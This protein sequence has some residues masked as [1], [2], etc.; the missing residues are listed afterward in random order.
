M[1]DSELNLKINT[2]ADKSQV[3]DLS[4]AIEKVTQNSQEASEIATSAMENIANSTDSVS[5]EMDNASASTDELADSVENIDSSN[6]D[7][8]TDSINSET[9]ATDEAS[10]STDNLSET[11]G[12]IDSTAIEDLIAQMDGYK[13]STDDANDAT[14][15]LVDAMTSGAV[16]AGINASLMS[17][18][19]AAGNYK[20]TMVRLGYAMSGTSMS[21]EQAQEK[22]GSMISTMTDVTGRGAG[23]ARA[24]LIN[25]G[26][27]GISSEKTLTDSFNAISKSAYQMGQPFD[28]LEGAFQKMVLSGTANTRMLARFGISANDLATAMGVSADEVSDSFK[29]MDE[30]SRASVLAMALNTK[31]GTDVNENYKNSYEHLNEELQRAKDYFIRTAGETLLPTLIPAIQTAADVTNYLTG[32]FRG[33]PE[34]IQNFIGGALGLVGG[35]TAVGLGV[36]AVTKFVSSALSPFGSLWRYF[37]EIPDGQNLTKF[38]SHVESLKNSVRTAK[39]YLVGFKDSLIGVGRTAKEAAVSLLEAGKSALLS[40]YNALKS[41]GMWAIEKAQKIASSIASKTA[42][43][44]QW[45]LNIAMSANP[46]YL[47]V[48]AIVALIAVLSYL[49]FNNEQVRDAINGLGQAFMNVAQII[50][51]SIINCVNWVIGALQNLWNY[52]F[53]LGGLLPANVNITGNQIIDAVLRVMMFIST[54]PLQISIIFINIIAQA[55][56]FGNNFAQRMFS[57]GMNSVSRFMSQISQLPSKL[58]GELNKMLSAVEQWAATLPQKF[59]DAGVNAVQ[60]FLNALGIHSPGIM[61]KKLIAEMEDTG[62]RIPDAS[63][64]IVRNVGIVG[65]RI[66]ESFG[67]PTFETPSFRDRISDNLNK[68]GNFIGLSKNNEEVSENGSVVNITY[69]NE[70]NIDSVDSEDRIDEL[71]D[72]LTEKLKF[73][74]RTAGRY[75]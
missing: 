4:T 22:Y 32:V 41:A 63:Y 57:A 2:E 29:Q 64:N 56:G 72:K 65:K 66:I 5:V 1:A 26:N 27:V 67:D 54:L 37:T 21:A 48:I 3:E 7:T 33:I 12:N 69:N 55:L 39:T 45:L 40:G 17:S 44:A 74:N 15:S 23:S 20:D 59:W 16:S 51:D 53:T 42:A 36:N 30:D 13:T 18:A 43:A 35:L 50:Y 73:D 11:I 58:M 8:V 61:Q 52:I 28:T 46:I 47:V 9:D 31:Y 25:L 10:D 75:V 71:I 34:P 38:R 70:F 68:V 62:N 6:V 24:H 14:M 49:Y 19:N 60:N